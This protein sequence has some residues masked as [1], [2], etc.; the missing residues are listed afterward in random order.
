LRPLRIGKEIVL[1]Q[2]GEQSV[3]SVLGYTPR[4]LAILRRGGIAEDAKQNERI[5]SVSPSALFE[6]VDY[7]FPGVVGV[8]DGYLASLL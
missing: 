1:P 4:H 7:L 5:G 2:A 8:V 3:I 6:K